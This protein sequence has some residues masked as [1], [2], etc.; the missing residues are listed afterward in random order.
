MIEQGSFSDFYH[1]AR[2]K[3]LDKKKPKEHKKPS[4]DATTE[5]LHNWRK[6]KE[7]DEKRK[8]VNDVFQ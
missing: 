6:K 4:M 3:V 7:K 8:Y 1:K 5:K 2:K